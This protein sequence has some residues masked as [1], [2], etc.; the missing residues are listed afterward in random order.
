ML[1]DR[2]SNPGPLTYESGALPIALRSPATNYRCVVVRV[3]VGVGEILLK[4]LLRV[5]NPRHLL[6][7]WFETNIY[8]LCFSPTSKCFGSLMILDVGHWYLWLFTL[9][10]NIKIGKNSCSM[11]D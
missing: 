7:Q 8:L 6:L 10:I 5:S 3:G 4:L 11:L 9:Y 1:P 2:V